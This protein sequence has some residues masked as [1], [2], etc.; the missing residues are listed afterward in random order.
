MGPIDYRA[1]RNQLTIRANR[2]NWL[3]GQTRP[4]DYQHKMDQLTIRAKRSNWLSGQIGNQLTIRANRTNWLPGQKSIRAKG[5]NCL[6][7]QKGPTNYLG[8]RDNWLSGLK[9]QLTI[10]ANR[11]NWLLGQLTHD[12]KDLMIWKTF[13]W[14]H[15]CYFK[16]IIFQGSIFSLLHI[17]VS[18]EQKDQILKKMCFT[19]LEAD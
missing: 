4:T 11:T 18:V 15:V 12:K 17:Y 2:T 19:D 6:S 9:V 3:S 10:R 1:N 16:C 14:P 7:G 13:I 8:K 5:T